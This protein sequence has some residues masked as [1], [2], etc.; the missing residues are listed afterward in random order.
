[1]G[2]LESV[3]RENAP[4]EGKVATATSAVVDRLESMR[5]LLREKKFEHLAEDLKGLGS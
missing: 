1:M 5:L 4:H 2:S 3:I